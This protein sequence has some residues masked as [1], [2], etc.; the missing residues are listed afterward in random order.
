MIIR[1]Y[2]RRAVASSLALLLLL[3]S[4]PQPVQAKKDG[5]TIS[6][7]TFDNP[8]E[9]V[10]YFDDSDVVLGYDG[11]TGVVWRSPD[12][13]ETWKQVDDQGQSGN[14]M[15]VYRHPW[16]NQRAYIIGLGSEHWVTTD[17]GKTWTSF[18][19]DQGDNLARFRNA[20]LSFHGRDPKRVI[21]NAEHCVGLACIERAFYTDDD[22]ETINNLGSM[23]RGCQWAVSTPDF[24]QEIAPEV[25]DRIFCIVEGLYSPWPKDNRLLVSDDFF[26]RD[27]LEPAL[28]DGR[29]VTGIISMAAVK[30]FLVAAAKSE[31][32]D[33][34]ALYVTKDGS[35]WHRAEF[36]QH[37]ISEDA[38][39]ILESTNYSL[40]VDVLGSRPTNPTGYLFTS[41]SNGTYFT[42]NIDH[43][44]RNIFGNV[45]FE[46]VQ[47]I[48]GIVMVNTVQNWKE[49]E[50]ST[51]PQKEIVSQ[52]SFDDGRTFQELKVGDKRLHLHSVTDARQTGRIFSS[53]APG[54]VMGIGN[55]GK[56]L[57]EYEDGDLFVSDDAGVTWIEGL[58]GAHLYEFGNQGAVIVAVD[59]EEPTS[60]I[61]YSIDHGKTWKKADLEEKVRARFLTTVP[62]STTLKF[63]MMGAKGSGSKTEWVMF[64]IDFDGL[65]ERACVEKDFYRWPARVDKDGKPSCLMGHKQF[66]RRRKADAECFIDEEFQDPVPE[67]EPCVCTK[68]DFECDYN[69][70]RTEDRK[71]C[72]PAD[73]VTLPVPE[74]A[75][76]NE[77]DTFKGPSGWR[78]IPGNECVRKGGEELDLDIERPCSDSVKRPISG[79]IVVEKTN[80]NADRFSE[81]YYLERGD[82]SI[83]SDETIVMR[84]SEQDIFLTRDHG[85]TWQTIL[86]G[87]PITAIAPNPHHHDAVFFLTGSEEVHYTIDR[88]DRFDKFSAPERP[89]T[90]RLPTMRFHPEYKDW[91]LWSGA[92][93]NDDHTNIWLSK[94]RGDRWD[95]MVRYARKCEFMTREGQAHGDQLI[96]CE[97]YEDENPTKNL[98]LL[99][100]DNFFADS[101]V[102]FPDILDF[103]TMSEFIIV[104]AKT[105]DRQSL[106]V[107]ASVDGRTFAPAE[108]PKNFQ[109]KHQQAYT[110]LDSSTHAVFLHVTV[111]AAQDHEYGAIIKS[112]SNG[113]SYV[114]TLGAVNR[115]TEGY[116]DFEK[117]QGLEGVAMVNVVANRDE[118]N[119]GE[120]KKLKSMITH[121][122]GAEWALLPPPKQDALGKN[123]PCVGDANKATGKC[124]L[125]IHSY[126]E[127]GDKSATFSSPSAVGL[128]M[129]VGNVGEYLVRKDDE[130]TDTFI[131]RDAGIT[132]HSV[133][134]GSYMWEYGDQGSII[135]IV[136]ESQ[137]TKSLFYT[138][139]EGESWKEFEFSPN[140]EMQID[141]ITTVPSD[142][143]RAFLLWGRELGSQAKRGI[144]TVHVDFSGLK[145]RERKCELD[146]KDPEKGDYTLWEPKHPMQDSNCL[147]GHIAR[148]HRK[149]ID[150]DCYNGKKIDHLHSIS[151]NCSCTRQDFEC[152]YNYEIQADGTCQLVPGLK[153]ADHEANCKDNPN[154]VEFWYPTGYRRI[155]LTTCQGGRELDKLESKPCP[156]HEEEYERKHGISGVGLFFAI[157]VPIALA[158]GIGYW[159]YTK[160]QS[161][162]G[163]FGQIRLGEG[164]STSAGG[165]GGG[166]PLWIKVPVVV[167]SG[168]VA[169]AKATP[170]LVMS[171]FRSAR[172]YMPLGGG[173]SSGGGRFGVGRGTNVGGYG[174]PYRSRDAFARRGQDYSQVV[175]DDELLGDGLDDEEE[176]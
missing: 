32:T 37:R 94:D 99:S 111:N 100:S 151:R 9:N 112:N 1:S 163:G 161:G 162:G 106:R 147:F 13:G 31:G 157:F 54:I 12:A 34:L 150:R 145:E 59:D 141:A 176:V 124:S 156:G 11:E 153:P 139:D 71:D 68:A 85:K 132:W 119:N 98:M 93:G 126:T 51:I 22:F 56:F 73:G 136:K 36:G 21:W 142:N 95:V 118:T 133:K 96:F 48:Q 114:Y 125:H 86:K 89:S 159:A 138:L 60:H 35:N 158:V 53:P 47:T 70:V 164:F 146:E 43:T 115:D 40:Q 149:R 50:G 65:H 5:P 61:R 44:N 109:V 88:G 148:Y 172:G 7:T 128:M 27:Q 134:K 46:K 143:S 105:E 92:V 130:A 79:D 135:V 6:S 57:K 64:K 74:G 80:F 24:A 23:T 18:S 84:T 175:E 166:D 165:A 117:M 69:F 52:I 81:W 97:Q 102:H 169:V 19:I 144:F 140:V 91:V 121:N 154:Q 129:A 10:F 17:T 72:V 76:K 173:S 108:F 14:V 122:D 87:E 127:R 77:K 28:D 4:S 110:V 8:L 171:L 78:L 75:C 38:Y 83:G 49:V 90:L 174:A 168:V 167:V 58:D 152:D 16:D 82:T 155:P 104:A 62:D 25:R 113:T 160:W 116:V 42:R 107:D 26:T 29:A 15:D 45:D 67:F 55:T 120:K 103:A 66:F 39:T 170:L 30:G 137:P 20:P 101:T 63:L 123:Y 41:N 2:C 33:E 3:A 131:T